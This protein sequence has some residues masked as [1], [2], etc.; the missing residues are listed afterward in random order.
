MRC[1]VCKAQLDEGPHCRRCRA[2]LSLLF[3]LQQQRDRAVQMA[4][5]AIA[6]GCLKR[7]LALALGAD[8]L[9][10]DETSNRVLAIIHLLRRDFPNAWKCYVR[11]ARDG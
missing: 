5:H 6:Q 4:Y 10:H 7:A 9:Q 3:A 1:I 8:A 11:Q 2:D